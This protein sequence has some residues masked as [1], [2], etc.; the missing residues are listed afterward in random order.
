MEITSFW[1]FIAVLDQLSPQFFNFL[2]VNPAAG[3][4]SSIPS[5][6]D[7]LEPST[8]IATMVFWPY[9]VAETRD[10][11]MYDFPLPTSTPG[12]ILGSFGTHGSS[13]LPIQ[14]SIFISVCNLW[15]LERRVTK[16][17]SLAWRD[18]WAKVRG[19]IDVA[20]SDHPTRGTLPEIPPSES[21]FVQGNM[22]RF[23]RLAVL[24]PSELIPS[25]VPSELVPSELVPSEL[26]PS[27]LIPSLVPSELVPSELI[28]SLVPS[29]LIPSLVPSELVPSELVPS[30]LVPSELLVRTC[31]YC[32]R[33]IVEFGWEC[34]LCYQ[35]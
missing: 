13:T 21:P 26:V 32:K 4:G 15:H 19:S 33:E 23:R 20:K 5:H 10:S 25:L 29:E 14:K 7:M 3:T 2:Y 30:E 12:D 16:N 6:A 1:A 34:S 22:H 9:Y 11:M 28:P 18:V 8:S 35:G 17:H 24:V 31:V 27:E